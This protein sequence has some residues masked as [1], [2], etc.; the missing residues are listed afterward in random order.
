MIAMMFGIVPYFL[1]NKEWFYIDEN[2][3]TYI[4]TDKATKKAKESY[5]TYFAE[6]NEDNMLD[7]YLNLYYDKFNDILP[8]MSLRCRS[9]EELIEIVKNCIKNKKNVYEIG[10]LTLDLDVYY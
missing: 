7:L 10:Y 6:L 5:E 9:V 2:K 1:T 3:Y 8:L 4:L